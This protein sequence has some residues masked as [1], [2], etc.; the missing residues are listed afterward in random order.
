[1]PRLARALLAAALLPAPAFAAEFP[2]AVFSNG[3]SPT[4]ITILAGDSL[5]FTNQGGLHNVQADDLSWRCAQGCSDSG[6]NGDASGAG[7]SFA[8]FFND[9]GTFRY[10]CDVHGGANGL[11]MSG[12]IVVLPLTIFADDF[13]SGDT[14]LWAATVP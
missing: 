7:W 12:V 11:G 8:R 3:Y 4:P 13:E 6:G 14:G 5:R 9:P 10:H 2:V 1:M